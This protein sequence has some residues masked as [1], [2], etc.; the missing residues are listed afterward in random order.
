MALQ[1]P[2]KIVLNIGRTKNAVRIGLLP[3]GG[4]SAYER[5]GDARR[6]FWIKPLKET[7]LGV[8][9]AFFDP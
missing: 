4:D 6:K 1:L 9:Q 3:G 5:G 7:N 2:V 8:A